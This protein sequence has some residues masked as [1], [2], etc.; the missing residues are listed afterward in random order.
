[1]DALE[2]DAF[3]L[4]LLSLTHLQTRRGTIAGGLANAPASVPVV[5]GSAEQSNSSIIFGDKFILKLFRRQQPGPNPDVEIGRFLTERTN[6]DRAP[7]FAGALEYVREGREGSAV[8]IVQE[9]VPNEGDGWIW[10][11]EEL[12]RYYETRVGR[13]ISGA[14]D[15]VG[16]YRTAAG[17]LGKR[18]AELHM[19]LA[20]SR[21][22][23]AFA[24]EPFDSGVI[25]SLSAGIRKEASAA[26]E[27]LRRSMPNLA[28]D[29]VDAA[30]QALGRRRD[31]VARM[32][33]EPGRDYGKR[34]RTHGDY[35]LG[36]VLRSKNDFVILDFEG[37]P[38]RSLDQR[39]AKHS[40]LRDVAGM[41]RSF[42]YAA[43]AALITYTARHPERIDFLEPWAHLW[44]QTVGA[45]FVSCYRETAKNSDILPR[46]AEDFR[47]LLDTY[48]LEKAIYELMYELNNRPTWVSI[49]I[50]GILGLVSRK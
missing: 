30:A 50:N 23:A 3:C 42:S 7:R 15:E 11:A 10:T 20:S 12:K 24:P 39:R 17:I 37:E 34:T 48:L 27:A 14:G 40:P 44:E 22:D 6:F 46:D 25:E 26:F 47:S 1:V 4:A 36:Q 13:N 45:E 41:L 19:A 28:E 33:L 21:D 35:H 9:L 43:H 32:N 31:I 5:H 38:A 18:T 16:D 49:P 29:A 2:D 8:A